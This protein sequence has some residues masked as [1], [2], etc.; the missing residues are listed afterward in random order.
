MSLDQMV[1]LPQML[2]C[3]RVLQQH[4]Q[5]GSG[6][7][8]GFSWLLAGLYQVVCVLNAMPKTVSACEILLLSLLLYLL[9][10]LGYRQRH[11]A[12]PA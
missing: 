3:C 8:H 2:Y 4:R 5:E 10:Y 9:L 1:A 12:C 11:E 7:M 6:P